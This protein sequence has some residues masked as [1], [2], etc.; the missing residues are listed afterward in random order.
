[1]AALVIDTL[2][3][4]RYFMHHNGGAPLSSAI[5]GSPSWPSGKKLPSGEP[6]GTRKCALL[7][8]PEIFGDLKPSRWTHAIMRLIELLARNPWPSRAA[9]RRPSTTSSRRRSRTTAWG[10]CSGTLASPRR[11]W[12]SRTFAS[13]RTRTCARAPCTSSSRPTSTTT[14]SST[15]ATRTSPWSARAS[16][17]SAASRRPATRRPSRTVGR[18]SRRQRRPHPCPRARP[19]L[20]RPPP[21][22]SRRGRSRLAPTTWATPTRR[23][24][25]P[26]PPRPRPDFRARKRGRPGRPRWPI[27]R[28]ATWGCS[29]LPLARARVQVQAVQCPHP[30]A[31]RKRRAPATVAATEWRRRRRPA[32]TSPASPASQAS[33]A[34]RGARGGAAPSLTASGAE[35]STDSIDHAAAC[36][37]YAREVKSLKRRISELE[38]DNGE[39]EKLNGEL[40][41]KLQRIDDLLRTLP[42]RAKSAERA[43]VRVRAQTTHH[44]ARRRKERGNEAQHPRHTHARGRGRAAAARGAGSQARRASLQVPA[45]PRRL[46]PR[47]GAACELKRRNPLKCQFV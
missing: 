11:T 29:Q 7:E 33:A 6:D 44:G 31:P 32:A 23:Q 2:E 35:G 26:R 4:F 13:S 15:T 27:A 18:R 42:G 10:R 3:L 22:R 19:R 8:V 17:T 37:D 25:R 41:V 46:P 24:R 36:S 28:R 45:S 38:K 30:D 39:H 47:Q 14:S 5:F 43:L 21:P 34:L 16:T 40:L 1:M 20:P 12:P 9:S